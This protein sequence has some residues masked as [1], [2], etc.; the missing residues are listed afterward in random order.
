MWAL[1]IVAVCLLAIDASSALGL[2]TS[3]RRLCAGVAGASIISFS[4]VPSQSPPGLPIAFAVEYDDNGDWIHPTEK[5]WQ[6]A[7]GDRAKK[8]STMS[9]DE[10]FMAA[11]GASNRD[12]SAGPETPKAKKRRAMSGC[13]VKGV[14]SK[15]GLSEKDCIIRVNDGGD[16][17]FILDILD[18]R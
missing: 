15:T 10:I 7:W 16:P 13:R 9:A 14:V 17:S 11:Q 8:A 6:E 4:G 1:Y 18:N 3:L 2:K 12:P 5:S